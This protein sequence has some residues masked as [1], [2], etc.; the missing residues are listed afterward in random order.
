MKTPHIKPPT[1]FDTAALLARGRNIAARGGG[2][3]QHDQLVKQTEKWVAQTF[4]GTLLKQMRD[5]PFHSDLME[6]GNGGK[7]FETMFDQR[8]ADHMSRHA[9]GKLVQSI[10]KKI[11]AA[12]AAKHYKKASKPQK[13]A[14]PHHTAR[15]KHPS[16]LNPEP[17]TL[18]PAS[19]PEPRT[20][21]PASKPQP[22]TLN[23]LQVPIAKETA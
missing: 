3:D 7:T 15:S 18:N 8:L 20:L 1:S 14:A 13:T 4:Y 6:G 19:N 22:R 12:Q 5:S 23:P 9:G 2:P 11:E 10:V 21:N 17:R 16:H